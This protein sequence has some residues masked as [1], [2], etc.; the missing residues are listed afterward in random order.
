MKLSENQFELIEAYLNN[1]LSATDRALFEND[2]QTDPELLAEVNRQRELRLGLRAL[3]IQQRL[4]QARIVYKTSSAADE[5]APDHRTN[6]RAF[7][8]WQSWAAAASVVVV[9]GV[10]YYAYQQTDS[11]QADIA[12]TETVSPNASDD[13][14][15]SF[16]SENVSAQT[17]T[18]FLDALSNYK[19][20]KYDRVI[21]QLRV[22][23]ADKKTVAYKNYLLGLSYL[24][25]KQAVQSIPLLT[26]ARQTSSPEL[27][28]KAEWFLA[29]AYIK[30]NQKERALPLLKRISSDKTHP[31]QSLAQRILAKIQ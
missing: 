11:R 4:E 9:L 10:G 20:G 23:P 1:E 31:F 25:N 19:A 26:K 24:A 15:K 28:R 29:L 8:R 13:L 14:L 21:E 3:G 16:P 17:R 22:L 5:S 7:P 18:T 6:V 2:L 30:N 27:Q 12:F